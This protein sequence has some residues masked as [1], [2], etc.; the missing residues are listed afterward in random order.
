MRCAAYVLMLLV[1]VS[2]CWADQVVVT[3]DGRKV[4]LR[5]GGTW[6]YLKEGTQSPPAPVEKF[7]K[8][9][10]EPAATAPP[11]TAG[12]EKGVPA[13]ANLHDEI[14]KPRP[15]GFFHQVVD[16]LPGK[17]TGADYPQSPPLLPRGPR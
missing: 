15:G 2:V 3:E 1:V 14:I 7:A 4:L 5:D 17:K 11:Q 10:A 13:A 9:P 12:G 16:T 6:K 8:K